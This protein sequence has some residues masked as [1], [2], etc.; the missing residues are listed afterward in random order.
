MVGEVVGE[1]R[2]EV[3]KAREINQHPCREIN[4]FGHVVMYRNI[5]ELSTIAE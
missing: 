5:K 1:E 4:I 2:R 3:T